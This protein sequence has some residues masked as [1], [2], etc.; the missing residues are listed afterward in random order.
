MVAGSTWEGKAELLLTPVPVPVLAGP[1][2]QQGSA[3]S[4]HVPAPCRTTRLQQLVA[5][6]ESSTEQEKNQNK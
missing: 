3:D 4:S 1:H 6:L 5:L 2:W